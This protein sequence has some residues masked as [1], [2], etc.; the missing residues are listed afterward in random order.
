MK[1]FNSDFWKDT[2]AKYNRQK[3]K[4]SSEKA[5]KLNF[6]ELINFYL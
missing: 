2:L 4:V 3:R 6:Y 5:K 1:C